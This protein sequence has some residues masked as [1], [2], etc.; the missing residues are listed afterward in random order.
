MSTLGLIFM[1]GHGSAGDA[2]LRTKGSVSGL[3]VKRKPPAISRRQ[4]FR[5]IRQRGNFPGHI[6]QFLKEFV[7]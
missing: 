6:D 7:I 1:A 3:Q 2:G 4:S 5:V